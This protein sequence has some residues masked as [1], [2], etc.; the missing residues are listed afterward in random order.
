V[1][2]VMIQ[3]H[4]EGKASVEAPRFALDPQAPYAHPYYWAPFFLMGNW[5]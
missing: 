5:L 4:G 3:E 1:R 2:G